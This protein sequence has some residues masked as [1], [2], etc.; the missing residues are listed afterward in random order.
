M[1]NLSI[2]CSWALG[3]IGQALRDDRF[4]AAR[5][6]AMRGCG[7]G[8]G[9]HLAV[10]IEPFLGFIL[11]G[12]KTIESRFAARRFA[13]FG[14]V[15]S[16]DIVLMKAASGPVVALCFVEQVWYFEL[17]AHRIEDLRRKFATAM[18]AEAASFW[19]K[20]R[21]ASFATLIAV[22]EVR[23]LPR[24]LPCPK[25]DRRSWVV[26]KSSRPSTAVVEDQRGERGRLPFGRNW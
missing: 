21:T 14:H 20:Q 11:D 12:T 2:W 24:P 1:K 5:I 7:S 8:A 22:R 9:I 16:G 18:R 4:W 23:V 26:L 6:D 3:A 25:R 15:C 17:D 19:E 13:P 10:L